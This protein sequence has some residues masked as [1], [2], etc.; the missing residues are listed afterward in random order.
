LKDVKEVEKAFIQLSES[1]K[2]YCLMDTSGRYINFT[3][4]AQK[5]LSNEASIVREGKIKASALVVNNLPNRF[6]A[7]LFSNFFKPNFPMKIVSNQ[8]DALN[9]LKSKM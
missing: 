9:W 2:I 6:V 3:S 7:Q 8:I 4:D 1:S 5:F